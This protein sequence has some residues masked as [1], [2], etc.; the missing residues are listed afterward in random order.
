VDCV[1][2]CVLGDQ[3]AQF[4]GALEGVSEADRAWWIALNE[5]VDEQVQQYVASTRPL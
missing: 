2:E 3:A 1:D 5:A 4:E